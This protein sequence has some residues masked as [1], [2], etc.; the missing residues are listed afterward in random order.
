MASGGAVQLVVEV[1]MM[2]PT[3]EIALLA[4][5]AGVRMLE[6]YNVKVPE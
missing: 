6:P 1:M 5:T 4:M 2:R 3:A